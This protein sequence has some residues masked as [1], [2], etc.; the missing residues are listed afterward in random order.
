MR[1]TVLTTHEIPSL[2]VMNPLLTEREI[3][4]RWAE[5]QE[6]SL[7]WLDGQVIYYRWHAR[8]AVY[9]AYLGKTLRLAQG[10][11]F[12]SEVFTR[13]GFRKQG[14][15][16]SAVLWHLHRMREHGFSRA[17]SATAW[18]NTPSI[19]AQ[20]KAGFVIAGRVGYWNRGIWQKYF[21]NGCGRLEATGEI[22]IRPAEV[23]SVDA[24]S[25]GDWR[26]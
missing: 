26:E 24:V 9:L 5:G 17:V 8:D 16:G 11:Y 14:V 20:Q 7:G 4:R 23:R 15:F 2:L 3:R 18:W 21:A 25:T 6:C 22:S 1:W 13:P 12:V 10:D 19:R